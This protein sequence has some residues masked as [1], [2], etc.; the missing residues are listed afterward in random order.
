[1]PIRPVEF[2]AQHAAALEICGR[3]HTDT[4]HFYRVFLEAP[5]DRPRRDHR[6]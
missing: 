6:V 2:T 3:M 1:V 4:D 5:S